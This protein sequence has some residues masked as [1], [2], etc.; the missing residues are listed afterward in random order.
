MI[1]LASGG[2]F[3]AMFGD[4]SWV[5]RNALTRVWQIENGGVFCAYH[6]PNYWHDRY[7]EMLKELTGFESV[8]VFSTGSE[9]T[10]AFWRVARVYNGKPGIWGGLVDP[11]EVGT[12]KPKCD[13]MHGWTLGALIMAGRMTWHEI[14]C[15]PE[16]GETRFGM[17]PNATCGMIMEPYHAPSGQFHRFNPTIK[18]IMDRRKE[19]SDILFCIDEIQGGFGRTGK[20]WAYQHYENSVDQDTKEIIVNPLTPDFLTIG[21]LAGGGFPVS[22][23]LG[24]KEVMESEAVKKEGHLSSTHAGNPMACSVGCAVIEAM[25]EMNLINESARKGLIL[26]GHLSHFPIRTHGRGL[27]AGLEL[28]NA[29]ESETVA[30]RCRDRGVWVVD[31]GR[32][33]VKIGP[34]LTIPDDV[35]IQGLKVVQE[36][37]EEVVNERKIEAC[38]AGGQESGSVN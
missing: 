38:G 23:L 7:V 37:V 2:I 34:E 17:A 27:M 4:H 35:L 36:V 31:T 12:E 24:P 19:F 16:L 10:E 11:D 22:A 1:D 28:Q 20:L 5:I 18:R 32:K 14:G 8:A 25:Q 6:R 29:A 13:A 33:W 3:A 26:H 9:A 30:N 21:K 15:Y